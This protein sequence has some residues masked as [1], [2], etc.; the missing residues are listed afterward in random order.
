MVENSISNRTHHSTQK[1]FSSEYGHFTDD[2][3]EYI[4]TRPDTPRPWVNVIANPDYGFVVSQNGSGFSW[5]R[6]S[7]LLRLNRWEQDLIRDEY[8]KYFISGTMPTA[9]SGR[10]PTSRATRR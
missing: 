2:G 8:G 3:Q 9:R 5:R 1:L 7:Q 4:I 6:N 10:R